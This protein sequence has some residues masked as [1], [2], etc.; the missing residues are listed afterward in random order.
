MGS[1][2][3]IILIIKVTNSIQEAGAAQPKKLRLTGQCY[4]DDYKKSLYTARR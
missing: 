3:H 2:E 4:G 1:L